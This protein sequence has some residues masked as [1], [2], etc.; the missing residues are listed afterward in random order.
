MVIGR[1]ML[2]VGVGILA[3]AAGSYLLA[4]YLKSMLFEVRPGDPSTYLSLAILLGMT[5]LAAS[6]V[7]AR[8]ATRV[9]PMIALHYE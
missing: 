3:G 5:A 1:T 2:L 4:R 6:L 9:D 8:R 7:P